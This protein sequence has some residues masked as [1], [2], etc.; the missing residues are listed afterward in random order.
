[1][2]QT[3]IDVLRR[4]IR[5]S[6]RLVR[7]IVVGQV[8]DR[9]Q[10]VDTAAE[11]NL[12]QLGFSASEWLGYEA[13]GWR[14][15]PRILPPGEVTE[16][17]VFLDLGS[18]KGRVLF[19]AARDYRF[20]RVIGVELSPDLNE[21]ATANIERNRSRLRCADV[22]IVTGDAA[23]YRI[24]DDVSVIYLYNPFRGPT[25]SRAVDNV[26]ASL[27]RHPRRLRIVYKSPLEED[28]LL[29]TGRF[30]LV[31]ERRALRPGGQWSRASATRLYEAPPP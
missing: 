2:R 31:R 5:P 23:A 1:M 17:D 12:A 16:D 25:F 24:P 21:I 30:R 6:Y 27:E 13:S 4:T 8:V 28:R 22:Q 26:V 11:V 10:G 7:R 29:G 3:A 9:R 19:Q 14:V 18:G 20:G 15:L